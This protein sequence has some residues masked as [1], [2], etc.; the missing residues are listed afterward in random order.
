VSLCSGRLACGS[1]CLLGA[2]TGCGKLL[3]ALDKLA[4]QGGPAGLTKVREL[5]QLNNDSFGCA[6]AMLVQEGRVEEVEI[7]AVTGKKGSSKST[8]KGIQRRHQP[9]V[10][11]VG[12]VGTDGVFA[13]CP[14]NQSSGHSFRKLSRQSTH[15][16]RASNILW[17]AR[18][19][20]RA[21]P[22]AGTG[23]RARAA[24]LPAPSVVG[25]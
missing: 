12:T 14:D 9:I 5:A 25:G 23:P 1:S 3:A 16:G 4:S 18:H 24:E 19:G 13:T 6:L 21:S 2:A 11:T 10:G 22:I 20:R 17:P 7:T 15:T 8:S